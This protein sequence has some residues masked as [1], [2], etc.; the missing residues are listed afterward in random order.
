[1]SDDDRTIEWNGNVYDL[2]VANLTMGQYEEIAKRGGPDGLYAM[3]EGI[4]GMKPTAWKAVFWIQDY[5]RDPGITWDGYAG[6]TFRVLLD[7]NVKFGRL[8]GEAAA[9]GESGKGPDSPSEP[10]G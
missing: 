4:R 5:T 8:A 1:M 10:A 7:A 3:L 9:A 2:D 6:P